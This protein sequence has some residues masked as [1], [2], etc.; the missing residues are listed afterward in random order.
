[1]ST[2]KLYVCRHQNVDIHK[3]VISQTYPNLTLNYPYIIPVGVTPVVS[4]LEKVPYKILHLDRVS[5]HFQDTEIFTIE[6]SFFIFFMGGLIGRP[7][8]ASDAHTS[9]YLNIKGDFFV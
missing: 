1:M 4:T 3:Y 9:S 2:S 6:T 5:S 7:R 8:T